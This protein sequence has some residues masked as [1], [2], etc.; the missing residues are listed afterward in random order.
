MSF[1]ISWRLSMLAFTTML[2]IIHL[3]SK[4][5]VFSQRLNREIFTFIGMANSIA[6]E[7]MA[8]IRTVRAFSTEDGE[9]FSLSLSLSFF[10]LSLAPKKS[11]ST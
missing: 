5:A 2:P 9:S 6:Q 4:Y 1:V 11:P 10:F 8:N 3:T 7:A